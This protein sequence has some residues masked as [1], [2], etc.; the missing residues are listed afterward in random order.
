MRCCHNGGCSIG[1]GGSGGGGVLDLLMGRVWGVSAG[2]EAAGL[3]I[4]QRGRRAA[5]SP[6]KRCHRSLCH[7]FLK[8][9][10]LYSILGLGFSLDRSDLR[11]HFV[12]Y[13]FILVLFK[14]ILSSFLNPRQSLVPGSCP[15]W[16][17]AT[18]SRIKLV[19]LVHRP[20]QPHH[21]LILY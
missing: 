5:A 11:G 20:I 9:C 10:S 19:A 6:R 7:C 8:T 14:R 15:R 12:G 3:A 16:S 2:L 1:G 13:S 4:G 18:N 21:Q 17:D